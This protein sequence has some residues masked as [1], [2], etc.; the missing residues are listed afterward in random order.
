M[1]RLLF[2]FLFLSVSVLSVAQSSSNEGAV[3][4]DEMPRV[5]IIRPAHGSVIRV[6]T[7]PAFVALASRLFRQVCCCVHVR[8]KLRERA[9]AGVCGREEE[10]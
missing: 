10:C 1:Q 8:I 5:H 6:G 4:G 7:C 9:C 2:L 3:D